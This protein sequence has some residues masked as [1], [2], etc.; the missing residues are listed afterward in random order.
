MDFFIVG[1]VVPLVPL[2][3]NILAMFL[4]IYRN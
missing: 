1:D 2:I 4:S 3:R